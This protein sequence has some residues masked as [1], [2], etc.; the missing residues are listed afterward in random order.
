MQ[1][2]YWMI[3]ITILVVIEIATLGLTTIWFAAGALVAF[4]LSL[5]GVNIYIQF[6]VFILISALL[7]YFI[8][9]F[10]EKYIN[11][12]KVATN[13]ESIIGEE[14]RVTKT[15]DNFSQ[16]GQAIINGQ[17]WT[18]RSENDE[19]IKEGTK[20]KIIKISGVKLIVR[21]LKEK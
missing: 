19:I 15:I 17:E 6:F 12:N 21:E 16:Q 18:A 8:R 5:L 14:A 4:F 7:L 9:P 11:A 1:A 3:A 2:L 20:V 10:A 13:V